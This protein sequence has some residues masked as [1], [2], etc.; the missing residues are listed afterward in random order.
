MYFWL[1]VLHIGTMAVWFTGLLFLPRLL[2]V[3]RRGEIDSDPAYFNRA[4]TL[5][6]FRI[7]TPAALVTTVLGMV[8]MAWNPDG[9]WLVMKLV[10]V[11]LAV[12]VHL[13]L[14]M[15][16]SHMGQGDHRH[17]PWF[18]RALGWA[19]LV[20]LL[21]IAAVTGAKPDTAAG[22]PPPPAQMAQ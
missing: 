9:A 12:L 6:F 21:A 8:L 2:V 19:P 10:L 16:L 11:S 1:K 5:L 17:G 13:Y 4:A 7:M 22:L 3:H 15:L 18:Y 14:G 20:L